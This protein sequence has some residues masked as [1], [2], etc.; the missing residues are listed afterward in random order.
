MCCCPPEAGSAVCELPLHN[1]QRPLR[2]AH[3]CPLCG[4]RGKPVQGQTVKSLLSVSLR[5]VQ[6]IEH[7]F[8][9]TQTCPVVYFSPDG[10]QTFTVAQI[11]ERVFQKEPDGEG[12][13]SVTASDI[14][15]ANCALLHRNRAGL[16]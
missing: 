15:S 12:I 3:A 4:E 8:C 7:L 13:L 10:E 16:S 11:R 2:A 6:D 9:K 5:E 14:R 1:L